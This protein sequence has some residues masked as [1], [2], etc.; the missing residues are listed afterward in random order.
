MRHGRAALQCAGPLV[1]FMQPAVSRPQNWVCRL[2]RFKLQLDRASAFSEIRK[3]SGSA[4][5][6]AVRPFYAAARSITAAK[7]RLQAETVQTAIRQGERIFRDQKIERLCKA[8]GRS[9]ILRSRRLN[10]AAAKRS[11]Q[12]E[13]VQTAIRQ[14][15]RIFRDQ[16]I[17]R[18]CQSTGPLVHFTPPQPSVSRPQNWVCRLKRFKLQLD[19]ASTFSALRKLSGS[20]MHRAAGPFTPP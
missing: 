15:E 20:A 14:G 5:H 11:L 4:K 10:I 1:H 2:K 17:E 9:S 12:A 3:L 7:R 8:Q 6:R 19:R 16:K 18:L 13:T